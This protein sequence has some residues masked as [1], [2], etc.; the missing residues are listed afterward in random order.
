M[1]DGD[2][3]AA[4]LAALPPP[5]ALATFL[6][7]FPAGEVSDERRSL[8]RFTHASLQANSGDRAVARA[9]F[10]ALVRDLRAAG[11]TGRLLDEARR[12]LERAR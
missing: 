6:W 8:W 7:L 3:R 9:G 10:E 12:G 4:L 5:D 11:Q 1:L 2:A